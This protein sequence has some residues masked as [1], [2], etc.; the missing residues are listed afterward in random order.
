MADSKPPASQRNRPY[1][2]IGTIALAFASSGCPQTERATEAP[3]TPTPQPATP[4][5]TPT[6]E[7]SPTPLPTVFIP[8]QELDTAKLYGDILV[9][10]ELITSQ[11]RPSSVERLDPKSF[12]LKLEL[13]IRVP[14]AHAS[15]E[16]L[17]EINP[18]LPNVLPGL[19]AMIT[20]AKVS[21]FYHGLYENK[22]NYQKNRIGRLERLLSRHNFFDCETILEMTHPETGRKVLLIQSE[23]DVNGDGSDG[24]RLLPVDQTSPTFQPYT[25]YRWRKQTDNPNEFLAPREEKLKELEERFAVKGLSIEENRSLR[26]GID[27]LK[28]E[29]A[30]LK[31]YSYLLSRADPF[32]VVPGFMR[33]DKSLPF[34]PQLGD[35]AAVIYENRIYPAILGDVGPSHKMG[36]ASLRICREI[37]PKSSGYQRAESELKV[38]YLVFPG[39]AEPTAGPP[40]LEAWHAACE[41]YLQEIGGYQGTLFV[42]EDMTAPPPTPTPE[43]TPTPA[44]APTSESTPATEPTPTST[45]ESTPSPASTPTPDPA[46]PEPTPTP[47]SPVI[48]PGSTDVPVG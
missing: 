35:Y 8:R 7:P 2:V 30:D 23:M 16:K 3:P 36:E 32:I 5:P 9:S 46:S 40:N 39:T 37:N 25:S 44:L 29:I 34:A 48:L 31:T 13:K 26:S 18:D 43:P 42:W 24:D 47:T 6:P 12:E 20:D 14:E 27:K 45:P 33:R 10:S 22:V 41:K 4:I 11:G 17:S 19:A 1:W 15:L 38:T 28:V 21:N